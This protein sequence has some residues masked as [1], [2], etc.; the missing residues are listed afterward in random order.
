MSISEY[1]EWF[2]CGDCK[3]QTNSRKYANAHSL[4]NDHTVEEDNDDD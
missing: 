1:G 3:F 2:V 4:E